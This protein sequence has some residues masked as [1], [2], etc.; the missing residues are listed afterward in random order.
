MQKEEYTS[1]TSNS[2]R[3]QDVLSGPL[4]CGLLRPNASYSPGRV[5]DGSDGSFDII[6]MG[7]HVD[8]FGDIDAAL[9]IGMRIHRLQREEDSEETFNRA[10]QKSGDSDYLG[11]HGR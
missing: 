2:N 6:E 1:L 7:I 4:G 8:R 3:I 11:Y 9:P 10:A 5:G